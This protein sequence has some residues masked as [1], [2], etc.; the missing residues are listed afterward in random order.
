M[1]KFLSIILSAAM[2]CLVFAGCTPRSASNASFTGDKKNPTPP[3]LKWGMTKEDT[4]KALG[5]KEE[6]CIKGTGENGMPQREA[7]ETKE[8]EIGG[9][10]AKVGVAFYD[11]TKTGKDINLGLA[12]FVIEPVDK[13]GLEKIDA[14]LSK[15]DFIVKEPFD[16]E[17]K[18][19]KSKKSALQVCDEK[20][21]TDKAISTIISMENIDDEKLKELNVKDPQEFVKKVLEEMPVSSVKMQALNDGGRY[22]YDGK[23]AALIKYLENSK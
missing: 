16:T 6:D 21:I 10:K 14:E 3:G 2:V 22:Y 8:I 7:F 17:T 15:G 23:Y 5:I 9:V 12:E 18:G 13:A 11:Y 1:K 4:F 19:W 20:K